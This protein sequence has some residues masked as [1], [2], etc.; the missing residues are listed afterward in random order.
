[1][2]LW[3]NKKMKMSTG[4]AFSVQELTKGLLQLIQLAG[5]E[6]GALAGCRHEGARRKRYRRLLIIA[7]VGGRIRVHGDPSILTEG[8]ETARSLPDAVPIG[9][10]GGSFV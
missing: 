3:F 10:G 9:E 7:L 5:I 4:R 1:M 2:P 6:A 8:N